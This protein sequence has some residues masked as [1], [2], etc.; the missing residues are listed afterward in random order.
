MNGKGH[1]TCGGGKG[2]I[3]LGILL[4]LGAAAFL[5]GKLGFLKG[6]GVWHIL[7]TI[8]FAALLVNGLVRRSF[9]KILFAMAFIVIVNDKFLHL[10]AIAPWPVLFAACLGT[11]G[12]NLLFPGFRYGGRRRPG[13]MCRMVSRG[14][15]P[16]IGT[17]T[18]EGAQ[19]TCENV[20]G[21]AVKYITGEVSGVTL[22]NAFGS[23]EIYF[24]DAVLKN[25]EAAVDVDSAFGRVAL[26]IPAGWKVITEGVE[27]VFGGELW[28]RREESDAEDT[29]YVSGD[30]VFGSLEIRVI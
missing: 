9:G 18:A 1:V 26:Y 13:G 11:I 20:F 10:E 24:S 17:E 25:H 4:L 2:N 30:I 15:F 28:D 14:G 7:F 29:L 3:F 5:A 6:V 22:D 19:V 27:H 21:S 23:M 16:V 8:A 12:L